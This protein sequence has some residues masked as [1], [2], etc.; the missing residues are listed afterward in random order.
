MAPK[1]RSRS[2]DCLVPVESSLGVRIVD[3]LD[4][5]ASA[6]EA[7]YPLLGLVAGV[8]V[9]VN[10]PRGK[11]EELPG[12]KFETFAPSWTALDDRRPLDEAGI[13]VAVTVM[14]PS[15]RDATLRVRLNERVIVCLKDHLSGETRCTF[16][17]F[18][19]LLR[20]RSR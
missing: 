11:V 9:A 17:L 20:N 7:D 19:L 1:S 6:D 3:V 10:Y 18:K 5:G 2:S 15:R 13:D 12:L 8:D 16:G 14:V 4:E